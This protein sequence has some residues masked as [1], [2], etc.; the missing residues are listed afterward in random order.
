M[1]TQLP[2]DPLKNIIAWQTKYKELKQQCGVAEIDTPGTTKDSREA[3]HDTSHATDSVKDWRTFWKD[4]LDDSED[5]FENELATAVKQQKT[6][7]KQKTL[8]IFL[9]HSVVHLKS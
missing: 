3:L 5:N 9:T 7:T 8:M 4:V 1:T 2:D 6:M